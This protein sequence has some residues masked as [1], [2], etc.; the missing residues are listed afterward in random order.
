[1]AVIED[2]L[3]TWRPTGF[4]L[5]TPFFFERVHPLGATDVAAYAMLEYSLE[6]R[7]YHAAYGSGMQTAL[8]D[9]NTR[10]PNYRADMLKELLVRYKA[11]GEFPTIVGEH[12]FDN[13]PLPL[14]ENDPAN[15]ERETFAANSE[16]FEIN[17]RVLA[18]IEERGLS[19]L[20][21]VP[22]TQDVS[23]PDNS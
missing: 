18:A 11:Q 15:A 17:E 22:Q 9:F 8:D 23:F 5:E 14:P 16:A 12:Y 1:M 21:E 2:S 20:N 10:Y 19:A 6:F 4:V 13:I 7:H 3:L